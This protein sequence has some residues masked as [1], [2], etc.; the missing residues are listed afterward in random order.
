M[1]HIIATAIFLVALPAQ[2]DNQRVWG[3]LPSYQST[4]TLRPTDAPGAVAEIVFDNK[5]VHSDED[6]SFTLNLDGLAVVVEA[7]LGR[8]MTP[9]RVAVI[10]PDGYI[11]IPPE[12]DVAEDDV[13][14][15]LIMPWVGF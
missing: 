6:V 1:R 3:F 8:G 4:I 15:V 7:S 9:D 11:A 2:A 5:T 13:G 12:M 10:P 14:V